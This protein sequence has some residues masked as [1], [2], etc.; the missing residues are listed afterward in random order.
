MGQDEDF[1]PENK[2]PPAREKIELDDAIIGA[3]STLAFA[4]PGGIG[5]AVSAGISLGWV[6]FQNTELGKLTD[7][8]SKSV[9]KAQD[10]TYDGKDLQKINNRIRETIHWLSDNQKSF[11]NKDI[12]AAQLKRLSEDNLKWLEAQEKPDAS[13]LSIINELVDMW[14]SWF[15]D[16]IEQSLAHALT[17]YFLAFNRRCWIY[18]HQ[19]RLARSKA[20]KGDNDGYNT[21]VAALND[22]IGRMKKELSRKED[23][24]NEK[25]KEF[26]DDRSN[27]FSDMYREQL[28]TDMSPIQETTGGKFALGPV[29]RRVWKFNDE[30]AGRAHALVYEDRNA[31]EAFLV[32]GYNYEWEEKKAKARDCYNDWKKKLSEHIERHYILVPRVL[33]VCKQYL[34][35]AEKILDPVGPLPTPMILVSL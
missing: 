34:S 7:A 30:T 31:T 27:S 10:S 3:C 1:Y 22:C 5:V 20:I 21:A 23:R 12:D 11:L 17:C 16:A 2:P 14:G 24:I 32:F 9:L 19:A 18:A 15:D 35:E 29:Q 6:I 28:E 13:L 25:I 33:E 8:T 4:V 26:K